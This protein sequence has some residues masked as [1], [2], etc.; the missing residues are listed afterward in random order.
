MKVKM[1]VFLVIL[2]IMGNV[3]KIFINEAGKPKVEIDESGLV[4][5]KKKDGISHEKIDIN[6]AEYE[7]FISTGFTVSQ[8]SFVAS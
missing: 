3:L 7:D 4:Y 6:K 2:V 1:I 8:A 5:K